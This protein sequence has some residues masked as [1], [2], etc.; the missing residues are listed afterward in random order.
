[1]ITRAQFKE[2]QIIGAQLLGTTG[3]SLRDDELEKISIADFGLGNLDTFGA[4]IL[5]LT[6]TDQ[7]AVKLIA[8]YS[9]QILPEHWHP[10]I[11]EYEGKEEILRVEYGDMYLYTPG[12][13]TQNPLATIPNNKIDCF[14]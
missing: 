11:N 13:P 4:Q 3:I 7:I 10:I 14:P 9:G 6:S 8:M 5:T 12:D 2:A 1:M